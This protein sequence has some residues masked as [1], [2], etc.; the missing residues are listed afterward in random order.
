MAAA[1]P[2][3]GA[4]HAFEVNNDIEL[5][6]LAMSMGW[7]G[8]GTAADP[9]VAANI[10]FN[11]PYTQ[12]AVFMGN[13]T[14]H[15]Q[16]RDCLFQGQQA[17]A[18]LL[19][20]TNVSIENCAFKDC[21]L[22]VGGD[23]II[24][25]YVS[26]CVFECILG[27][28]MIDSHALNLENGTVSVQSDDQGHHLF[29]L[30]LS[31]CSDVSVSDC[32]FYNGTNTLSR[33]SNITFHS[34]DF[35]ECDAG[36]DIA[37]SDLVRISTSSMSDGLDGVVL[38]SDSTNVQLVGDSFANCS[39]R[40]DATD[41]DTYSSLV[42]MATSIGGRPFYLLKDVNGG[43]FTTNAQQV[44]LFNVTNAI[45]ENLIQTETN[46]ITLAYC[47]SVVTRNCTVSEGKD[48]GVSMIQCSG[49]IVRNST[50]LG[51]LSGVAL[52]DW[53]SNNRVENSV[54]MGCREGAS[55]HP[56]QEMAE[57][58]GNEF[59]DCVLGID[60][61][62]SDGFASDNVLTDCSIGGILASDGSQAVMINNRINGGGYG[63]RLARLNESIVQQNRVEAALVGMIVDSG[64]A[65]LYMTDNLVANCSSH[66]VRI[67][68]D[69][70]GIY[71]E[72][73]RFVAN[74]GAGSTY[75][76]NHIQAYDPF[77]IGTW[78]STWGNYWSDWTANSVWIG[79]YNI[80]A[81]AK[82]AHPYPMLRCGAPDNLAGRFS[83]DNITVNWTAPSYPGFDAPT[84]YVVYRGES[85]SSLTRIAT[86]S[87]S[88]TSYVDHGLGSGKYYY[89]V[90]A[91]SQYGESDR[92]GTLEAQKASSDSNLLIIAI[93]ALLAIAAIIAIVFVLRR[94]K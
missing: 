5:V 47:E 33:C 40:F 43:T 83:G 64:N 68:L 52:Y 49:C 19:S 86:V 27:V 23:S 3:A 41:R 37:D 93:V 60:L 12:S 62:G 71:V 34:C 82:D 21:Y 29:G 56:L 78:N 81:N 55:V 8:S 18:M 48:Y 22:G 39:L 80:S 32:L 92:S 36:I 14:L 74:N 17:G 66:C 63:I 30:S 70:A 11:N 72:H 46:G 9:I 69:G 85:P 65:Q 2:V 24:N 42:V 57:V 13:T 1:V 79:A 15:F 10:T 61:A 91:V 26:G 75:S 76:P 28:I 90:T 73:N 50:F 53:G 45:L 58:T 35:L 88:V 25:T 77:G 4:D 87:G 51:G 31:N 94:K 7:P 6:D 67:Y 20:T 59:Q 84:S 44:L 38:G 54:F 16:L 89:Q